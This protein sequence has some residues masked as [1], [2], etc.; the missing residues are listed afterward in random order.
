[1]GLIAKQ[2]WNVEHAQFRNDPADHATRDDGQIDRTAPDAG[3]DGVLA[4]ER[5]ADPLV[6]DEALAKRCLQ[7]LAQGVGADLLRILEL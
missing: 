5:V 3:H 1:V 4:A 2:E 7:L 6:D